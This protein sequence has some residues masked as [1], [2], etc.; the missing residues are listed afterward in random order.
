MLA[1]CDNLVPPSQELLNQVPPVMPTGS[2]SGFVEQTAFGSL[3]GLG[4]PVLALEYLENGDMV[5]IFRRM[6]HDD[7][8][9]PNRLLVSN[10]RNRFLLIL[11]DLKHESFVFGSRSCLE[12]S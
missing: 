2:S 5:P 9:L 3:A 1:S 7:V 4:G 10:S 6:L 11:M 12:T 8:H